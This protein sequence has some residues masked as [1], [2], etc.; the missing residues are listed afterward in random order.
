MFIV[1]NIFLRFQSV[2]MN[3]TESYLA[4]F[5]KINLENAAFVKINFLNVIWPPRIQGYHTNLRSQISEYPD[6]VLTFLD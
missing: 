3:F 5:A 4:L 2:T 6:I 1:Q